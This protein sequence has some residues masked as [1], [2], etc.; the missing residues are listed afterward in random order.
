MMSA[1]RSAPI[2]R[3]NARWRT[4]STRSSLKVWL[5]SGSCRRV[6]MKRLPSLNSLVLSKTDLQFPFRPL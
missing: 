3:T 1:T 2:L 6:G 4:K 5:G